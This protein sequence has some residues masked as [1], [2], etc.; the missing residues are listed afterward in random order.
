MATEPR[1]HSLPFSKVKQSDPNKWNTPEKETIRQELAEDFE[2]LLY[3]DENIDSN[4]SF[5]PVI[6]SMADPVRAPL[7]GEK[8]DEDIGLW[9]VLMDIN[10]ESAAE[11]DD[12]KR[13][14]KA[15]ASLRGHAAFWLRD[16]YKGQKKWSELSVAIKVAL[17][18]KGQARAWDD[19]FNLNQEGKTLETYTKEATLVFS[20]VQPTMSKEERLRAFLR[21]LV[22]PYRE[23]RLTMPLDFIFFFFFF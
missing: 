15:I 20:R 9:V 19:L 8:P 23:H 14:L 5:D 21:G 16:V 2:R 10:F 1:Q 12:S 22:S 11:A 7:F 6:T 3:E 4:G 13:Y 17:D 18:P